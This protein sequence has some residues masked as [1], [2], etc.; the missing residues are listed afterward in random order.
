[1]ITAC[2]FAV[3]C[4]RIAETFHIFAAYYFQN[5][6]LTDAIPLRHSVRSYTGKPV[7]T[8]KLAILEKEME[9]YNA[10]NGICMKLVKDDPS[11]FKSFLAR[12]GKFRNIYNCV[13]VAMPSALENGEELCGYFG[14]RI[15]LLAQTLGLNTCW[16]GLTFSKK[17]AKKYLLPHQRLLAVIALG[18][19]ESQG[20]PHKSKTYSDVCNAVCPPQWFAKGVEAALLA[21]TALNK[22]NFRISL[23][24]NGKPMFST[25][26]G[27][28]SKIDLGIIKCHFD[29]AADIAPDS[30]SESEF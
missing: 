2:G 5:M 14:E 21:P 20:K 13:V 1:M 3:L 28:Y 27:M 29:L 16:A 12:Y 10:R 26:R 8:E 18:Y 4:F 6:N 23:P 22:Q 9:K 15:V 17:A 7:E 30:S 11:V 25:G 24:D 19:G